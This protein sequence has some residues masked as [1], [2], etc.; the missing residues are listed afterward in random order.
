MEEWPMTRG[1]PGGQRTRK[2]RVACVGVPGV[3]SGSWEEAMAKRDSRNGERGRRLG[4]RGGTTTQTGNLVRKN[5]WVPLALSEA[6]RLRAFQ[7][8]QSET[9]I[10]CTALAQYLGVVLSDEAEDADGGDES[11]SRQESGEGP[12]G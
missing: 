3:A 2:V 12:G 4:P 7:T 1:K 9:R 11:A 6:L 8:R 10:I 5:L